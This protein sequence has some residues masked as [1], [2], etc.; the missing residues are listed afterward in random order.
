MWKI[1]KTNA[2]IKQILAYQA[3]LRYN[4][5]SFKNRHILFSVKGV[6]GTNRYLLKI[7]YERIWFFNAVILLHGNKKYIFCIHKS[8][9]VLRRGAECVVCGNT[10]QYGPL[11]S[12]V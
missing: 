7:R 9:D 8:A 2:A 12:Q 4:S 5:N 3:A 6:F 10:E 11:R 1:D